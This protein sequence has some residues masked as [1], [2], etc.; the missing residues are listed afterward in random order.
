MTRTAYTAFRLGFRYGRQR[1]RTR[2]DY[3]ITNFHC[4]QNLKINVVAFLGRGRRQGPAQTH[5]DRGA[6]RR[7]WLRVT[8]A[9]PTSANIKRAETYSR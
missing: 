6:I 3:H 7:N 9:N 5:A 2:N 4:V 8:N 1:H